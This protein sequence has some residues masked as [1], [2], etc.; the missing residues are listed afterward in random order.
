MA[1][2]IV[3]RSLSLA[4]NEFLPDVA[5]VL[6]GPFGTLVKAAL[7]TD[8]AKALEA[9][10]ADKAASLT[11]AEL[12]KLEASCANLANDFLRKHP[13]AQAF[14]NEVKPKELPA[15]NLRS[16]EFWA[17][18]Q[19]IKDGSLRVKLGLAVAA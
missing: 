13:A 2:G 12:A 14:W 3:Q 4:L 7:Q 19:D 17:L 16:D 10:L 6:G 15:F 9:E 8:W 18:Q 5:S 1:A 11:S